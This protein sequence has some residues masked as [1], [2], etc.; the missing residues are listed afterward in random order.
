MKTGDKVIT[1]Q[2]VRFLIKT[3]F[4]ID[5][6]EGMA[7]TIVSDINKHGFCRVQFDF[8]KI[9]YTM[10]LHKDQLKLAE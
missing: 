3:D 6:D 9:H 1:L 7:G 8:G 4:A 2:S 5:F 10:Y